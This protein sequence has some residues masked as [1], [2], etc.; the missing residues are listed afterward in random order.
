MKE[1]IK[2]IV[3]EKRNIIDIILIFIIVSIISIPLLNN[4]L[5]IY[6][7]DGIQHISRA[8]G[9]YESIKNGNFKIIE[10]LSNGFGYS[11]NLFYGPLTTYG[12]IIINLFIN[13]FIISYKIFVYILLILSGIFMYK[14]M[15]QMTANRNISLLAAGIYVLAP[16]HLTDLYV[17][18]ALGEFASFVFIPLVFWGLYNL[19]NNENKNFYLTVGAVGLILTHNISTAIT[20]IF[21]I[22]YVLTNIIKFKNK[23]IIKDFFINILFIILITSFFWMPLLETK[24]SAEYAAYQD[25]FMATPE[26]VQEKGLN[27]K[28][29][30]V[31]FTNEEFV[32]EIGPCLILLAFSLVAIRNLERLKKE[33][34]LFLIFSVLSLF[35]A[36]K[37]FPWK[38]LPS[39]LSMIQF[40]W[41]MLEF[42]TFFLSV[43]CSINA[44]VI[45]KRFNFKDVLIMI[46]V[47][48]MYIIALNSFIQIGQEEI[49]PIE[50][51][52]KQG[53]FSGKQDEIVIG[54]AKGE[55]LTVNANN[56]KFYLATREDSVYVISGKAVIE[57]EEK[58]RNGMRFKVKNV[59][60]T[61]YELPYI[62]YPGYEIRMDGIIIENHETK[63]G[64]LGFKLEDKTEATIEVKYVGTKL[65]KF[66]YII[67]LI[68]IVGFT[69]S[70]IKERK[71]EKSERKEEK[72]QNQ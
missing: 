48:I 64:F 57:K 2:K 8:Y 65:M 70:M 27:V 24:L 63:N 52:K 44:F 49:I 51:I 12:I 32:F 62:Y 40:P 17:R 9:T 59:E 61:E 29:L 42:S 28:N 37:Y 22:I 5:N 10:S 31:T 23:R 25:G 50:E 45:I 68:G 21:A 72:C 55:Y 3:L 47:L 69:I 34:I 11:W 39:I 15:Y 14:F 53:Y 67:S 71:I 66:S 20:A 38:Y 36:T 41:R 35:M 18:N 30:F 54:A 43:V 19:F 56:D 13:N 33:Y 60:E 58:N 1:K 4:R 26:S 16:Y 46:L 7:D 6:Y